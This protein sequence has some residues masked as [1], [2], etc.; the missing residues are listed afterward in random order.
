MQ[1]LKCG[2]DT[3]SSDVFCQ[4]CQEVMD[5]SPVKVTGPVILPKR[6]P[7][8]KKPPVKK[9]P[10]PEDVIAR[11]HLTIKRLWITVAVL[12]VLLTLCG[13]I[14]GHFIYQSISAPDIGSNYN[15]AAPAEDS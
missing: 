9:Q 12:A 14:L 8:E 6:K 5:A 4:A 15:T 7:F 10:K 3:K 1:C 2:R 11:L 13:G